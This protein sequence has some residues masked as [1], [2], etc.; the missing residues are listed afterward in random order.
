MMPVSRWQRVQV[1][2]A[3]GALLLTLGAFL[4]LKGRGF[5]LAQAIVFVTWALAFWLNL[6]YG[7]VR[8]RRLALIGA[9]LGTV[10]ALA[11]LLRLV[12]GGH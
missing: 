7:V 5:A 10:A 2:L 3:I 9:A 8:Y 11:A 1:A 4:W 12:L 6:R